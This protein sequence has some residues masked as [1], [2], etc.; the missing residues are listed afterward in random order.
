MMFRVVFWDVLLCKIIVD[1][2][3]RG[4]YSL[5]SLMMIIL[6]GSTSQKTIL[7]IILT[8]VYLRRFRGA[9]SLSSLMMI[10]LHG[11]TF[12]KTILNIILTFVN[13]PIGKVT[14]GPPPRQKNPA[15][16]LIILFVEG[17]NV[18]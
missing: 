6:H 5:S 8:F 17:G 10:I 18:L 9:Y 3:F 15:L 14:V 11:S 16:G 4:A 7:N 12:Q 1:R 2:R 13:F